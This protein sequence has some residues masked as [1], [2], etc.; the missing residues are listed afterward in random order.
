[1]ILY[2]PSGIGSDPFGNWL[3]CLVFDLSIRS[4][5]GLYNLNGFCEQ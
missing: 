4:R 3:R 1:M 5:G 2:E